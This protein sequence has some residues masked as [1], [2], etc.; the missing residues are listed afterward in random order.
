VPVAVIA[1]GLGT[2]IRGILGDVPKVLASVGGRPFLD[3]LIDHLAGFG[4]RRMVLCLGHL[5]DKVIVHLAARSDLPLAVDMVIDP[6]PLGT[7][8][9]LRLAAP[10]LGGG[11]ILVLN[12]DTW[13]D[14]D[15]CA[16]LASHRASGADV[17]ILCVPVTDSSR[18]A[19]IELDAAGRVARYAEKDPNRRGPGLISGGVYLFS[20]IGLEAL[21][22]ASGPSLER[23][24]LERRPAGSVH[25]FVADGA[26]FVDIGTPESLAAAA[27]MISGDGPAKSR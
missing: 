21:C 27:E 6:E 25:G 16:F 9:A 7:G 3:R 20:P 26:R 1:G 2:R 5:A 13:V 12:G 23:D 24:F 14:A 19:A 17:S 15:L 11:D 4:A 22:V 8:G 10:R 18:Y